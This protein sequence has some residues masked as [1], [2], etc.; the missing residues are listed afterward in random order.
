MK[1]A[2]KK[3]AMHQTF[4]NVIQVVFLNVF[5]CKGRSTGSITQKRENQSQAQSLESN[6][7]GTT[8][9]EKTPLTAV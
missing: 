7:V 5:H 2:V 9:R 6:R 1:V 3:T 4:I 8:K